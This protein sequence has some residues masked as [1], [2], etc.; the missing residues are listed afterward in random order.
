MNETKASSF[1]EAA[2]RHRDGPALVLAGPG[3]G[4]TYVL[5]HRL[6]FLT[7]EC[8]I[9]PGNI[10]V[11]TFT[12]AAAEQMKE[13]A[14]GLIYKKA[15]YMTFGTFHSVF[16]LI[17]RHTF[18]LTSENIL[19][20]S[21]RHRI[22]NEII[23]KQEI[24]TC[25]KEGLIAD[26]ISDISAFK[27]GAERETLSGLSKEEMTSVVTAYGDRLKELKLLDFDDMIIKCRELF[28][29]HSA[30]L[31]RFRDKYRYI[32]VDEFQ[33]VNPV[34][35]ETL[36]L[37]AGKRDNLFVVG[38]D[39]QAIYGFRGSTPGIMQTFLAEHPGVQKYELFTNYRSRST[40]V[41]A[42][43][44][45]IGHNKDRLF[46]K[47]KPFDLTEGR[48]TIEEFK[49]RNEE[50]RNIALKLSEAD[51]GQTGLSC[52]ILLRTN[53]LSG[54]YAEGL[55]RLGISCRVKGR[56]NSIYSGGIGKDIMDYMRFVCGDDSRKVFLNI[57]NKPERG[58]LG[59]CLPDETV[60]LD[61]LLILSAED[62]KTCGKIKRLRTDRERMSKMKP[63]MAVHY[64]L[65]AVGFK[66]HIKMT[67][68]RDREAYEAML[69]TA[70]EMLERAKAFGSVKEWIEESESM[71]EEEDRD[72][73]GVLITTMHSSKGLEFDTVFIPDANEGVIPPSR[74]VLNSEE[75]EERRLF[76][77]ALT[78]AKRT[79]FISYINERDGRKTPPS[80]FLEEIRGDKV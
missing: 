27:N 54:F 32:C 76:Y 8:G 69:E 23:K 46:K 28:L 20:S 75:E 62:L 78:R 14:A 12:R 4:K 64:L 6:K 15:P 38:D 80:R 10:L 71:T 53:A 35:Y 25:D 19:S 18:D 60:D 74:T 1:Q 67:A 49:D 61:R 52:A 39:D 42:S 59:I 13:R 51:I 29:K 45:L 58:I 57:M 33:D 48:L 22:L 77:V 5:T 9:P 16:F 36:C 63:F 50:L 73:E 66:D 56:I 34:Q 21:L 70:E 37:L 44:S 17:L 11:I 40:I 65:N 79:L 24:S 47:I 43:F 68:G 7:E 55:R 3:S 26:L 2:I 30:V 41:E 31:E 72:K